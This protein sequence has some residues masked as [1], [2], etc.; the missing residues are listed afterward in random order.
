MKLTRKNFVLGTLAAAGTAT[1]GCGDDTTGTGGSGG[2]TGGEAEGGSP[3]NG[4]GGSG[5]GGTPSNGGGGAGQGG[6]PS[7]GG[8]G[9]GAGL[10]C[11]E[12]IG[13]NHGHE[14]VVSEAD[15]LAAAD[16][17]YDIQGSS[18]HGHQITITAAQ[19]GM[20]AGGQQVMVTSTVGNDHTHQV[21]VTCA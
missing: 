11:T 21:T 16:K 20:L 2:G 8:G 19:F 9:G 3:S 14:L 7:E 18:G 1:F 6:T 17:I 13:T 15:V 5:Q 4:G 10:E 12:T